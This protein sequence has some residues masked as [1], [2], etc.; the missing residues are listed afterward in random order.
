MNANPNPA[1]LSLHVGST[2]EPQALYTL[3]LGHSCS[4]KQYGN[5][6]CVKA[7][8]TSYTDIH[9]WETMFLTAQAISSIPPI[10]TDSFFGAFNSI[11]LQTGAGEIGTNA[12]VI[13][14]GLQEWFW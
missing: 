2:A 1:H 8:H 11:G 7:P 5:Q 12:T 9:Y 3:S 14:A 4:V 13:T 6:Q 10:N